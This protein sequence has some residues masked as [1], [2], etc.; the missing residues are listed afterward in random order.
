MTS[1][2]WTN[3]S[4]AAPEAMTVLEPSM[5]HH[6]DDFVDRLYAAGPRPPTYL[7]GAVRKREM[8]LLLRLFLQIAPSRSLEWGLGSGISAAAFGEAR[9]LLGLVGSH[10]VLDPFQQENFRR[11]G[12]PLLGGI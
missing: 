12:P 2:F 10:I 4:E 6:M 3:L 7:C 1:V 9:R 11:L 5:I 8:K